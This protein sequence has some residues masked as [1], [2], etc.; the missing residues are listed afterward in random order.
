MLH[1]ECDHLSLIKARE[2]AAWPSRVLMKRGGKRKK[3]VPCTVDLCTDYHGLLMGKFPFILAIFSEDCKYDL[4]LLLEFL[5]GG[6]SDNVM[7]NIGG[8]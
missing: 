7:F 1:I 8:A 6:R 2:L 4:G 5:D 3:E